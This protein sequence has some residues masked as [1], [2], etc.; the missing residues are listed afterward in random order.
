M[1]KLPFVTETMN[2]TI[3]EEFMLEPGNEYISKILREV[4]EENPNIA[5]FINEF[6]LTAGDNYAI[7]TTVHCGLLVYKMLKSQAEADELGKKI[8]L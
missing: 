2:K 7:Q 4:T 1:A 8:T 6:S 5:S 3:G